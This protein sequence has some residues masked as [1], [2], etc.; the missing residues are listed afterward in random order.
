MARRLAISQRLNQNLAL[1][2]RNLMALTVSGNENTFIICCATTGRFAASRSRSDFAE[3]FDF[4]KRQHKPAE[5]EGVARKSLRP[6]PHPHEQEVALGLTTE[7]RHTRIL[8]RP[9]LPRKVPLSRRTQNTLVFLWVATV[10]RPRRK[11][12]VPWQGIFKVKVYSIV[13]ALTWVK[14]VGG[15]SLLATVRIE[16]GAVR[17]KAG[18]KCWSTHRTS[19]KCGKQELIYANW[20]IY[21]PTTR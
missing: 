2:S 17:L 18:E 15:E 11:L 16:E 9:S 14:N 12:Q 10:A 4:S 20:A 8:R 3:E 5:G 21:R 7:I 13:T 1:S 6:S 19:V